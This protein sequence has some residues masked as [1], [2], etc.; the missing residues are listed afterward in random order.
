MEQAAAL[1]A[2]R[3]SAQGAEGFGVRHLYDSRGG[4]VG[5]WGRWEVERVSIFF[6]PFFQNFRSSLLS[7][8]SSLEVA[9]EIEKK[10]ALHQKRFYER[11]VQRSGP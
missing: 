3:P 6:S 2:S 11:L 10:M 1:P 5:A 9:A 8:A 4:R 7:L